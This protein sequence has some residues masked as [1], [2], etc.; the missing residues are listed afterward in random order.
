MNEAL[1]R[2]FSLG[3]SSENFLRRSTQTGVSERSTFSCSAQLECL[4]EAEIPIAL[5]NFPNFTRTQNGMDL[6]RT[7]FA[8]STA[9]RRFAKIRRILLRNATW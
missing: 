1:F 8:P 5:W 7:N 2:D 3:L 6:G 4:Y 9:I